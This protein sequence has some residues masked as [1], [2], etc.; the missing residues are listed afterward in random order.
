MSVG[1][2]IFLLSALDT[3][4]NCSSHSR[5]L[6][7]FSRSYLSHTLK[8]VNWLGGHRADYPML[9]WV[10]CSLFISRVAWSLGDGLLIKT[11]GEK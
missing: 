10:T 3:R 5:W 7:V 8:V 4:K 11:P 9:N 1:F 6:S 2:R